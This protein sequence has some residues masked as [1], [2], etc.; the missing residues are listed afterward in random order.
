[1][2]QTVAER[3]R[4]WFGGM[5][6]KIGGKLA[7]ILVLALSV[8]THS[9]RSAE[10]AADSSQKDSAALLIEMKTLN[11]SLRE[12]SGLLKE[13]LSNQRFEVLMKRVEFKARALA[14]AEK[15]L[16]SMIGERDKVSRDLLGYEANLTQLEVEKEMVQDQGQEEEGVEEFIQARRVQIETEVKMMK[17][18]V[19]DLDLRIMEMETQVMIRRDEI[20]GWEEYLDRELEMD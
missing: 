1:M 18:R 20:L 7:L 17:R 12:I 13:F 2:Q 3:V 19:N 9:V 6:M 16:Q 14:E 11:E 5:K 15:T 10:A 8:S 4:L